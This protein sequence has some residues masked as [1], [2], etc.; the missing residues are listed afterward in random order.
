MTYIQ[1]YPQESK[2]VSPRGNPVVRLIGSF[3]GWLLFTF[4]FTLLVLGMLS[5]LRIGGTCADGGPYVIAQPC[6][7]GAL[8]APIGVIL[9]LIAVFL[10]A[11]LSK[12]FGAPLSRLAFPILF[13][14]LGYFFLMAFFVSAD[15]VGLIVGVLFEIMGAVPLIY[16]LVMHRQRLF[17]G[18][19]NINGVPFYDRSSERPLPPG[20]MPRPAKPTVRINLGHW[21]VSIV[22]AVVASTIGYY[23]AQ[24]LGATI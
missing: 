9:G 14:G 17:V 3:S 16:G 11:I 21:V 22:I 12:G 5:V 4:S 1:A 7:S 18:D 2:P 6:P 10:G 23:F 8:L 19:A 15:I 24:Q 20:V 13:C